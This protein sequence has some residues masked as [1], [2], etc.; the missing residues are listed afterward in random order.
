LPGI[1]APDKRI[2]NA[3]RFFR[4]DKDNNV[5]FIRIRYTMNDMTGIFK[6]C[7][8]V[9]LGVWILTMM[10]CSPKNYKTKSRSAGSGELQDK[11]A[12]A[13][14]FGELTRDDD[15]E[16]V[17]DV[18]NRFCQAYFGAKTDTLYYAYGNNVSIV[19]NSRWQYISERSAAIAW[20][21]NLPAKTYIEYGQDKKYGYQTA[22]QERYFF[23]HLHYLTKLQPGR[24]YYYR[25]VSLDETGRKTASEQRSFITPKLE[26]VIYLPGNQG[27]PPYVLD[28]ANTTYLVTEN[29]IADRSAFDIRAENITLDLGGNT[30][31][32]ASQLIHNLDYEDHANAGVGIRSINVRPLSGLKIY[33]GR[34]KQGD[35][36]NNLDYIAGDNMLDPDPEREK[37]LEKN[38]SR[39]FS[40]IEISNVGN[41][42]IAGV[43]VEYHL[44]QT[45]GMRFDKAF[46]SYDI[47]HNV[48]LD[49][50]VQMFNRHGDGGARSMGFRSLNSADSNLYQGDNAFK[51]SH[52]LVKRTRQNALNVAKQIYDNEIYVDSWSVN[53]FAIHPA[54]E[55]AEVHDNK[56][57]LTGYYGCG[58]LWSLKNMRV[59]RNFIHMEG[60]RTMIKK[61]LLGRRLIETWGEQ[62]VLAG[63]RVTNYGKGG[64]ERRDLL[65]EDNIIIGRSRGGGEMRGVEFFSDYSN[66][67]IVF[68]N[69]TVKIEAADTSGCKAACVDTQGAFNDRS[70]HLPV[71]YQNNNLISNIAIIRF[72]DEYGQG[73][74]HRFINCKLIRTGA[75]PDFHAFVFDGKNAVFNHALLDCEFGKGVSY[76]DVYWSNTESFSNYSVQWT[77]TL[78]T[79]PEARVTIRNRNGELFFS[80]NAGAKGLLDIPLVQSI[81]RPKEWTREGKNISVKPSTAFQEELFSPYTI[82]VETNGKSRVQTLEMN[83]KTTL[84]L[85]S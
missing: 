77:L 54:M 82:T 34:I 6:K 67:D 29:I 37:R 45:W 15:P 12:I 52:N 69:N 33:N 70:A 73:S 9:F 31:T 4:I 57:F 30:V 65:Y 40:N 19:E 35:A 47:H 41:V 58:I 36:K 44:P 56:I 25:I 48:Y 39:G 13:K 20:K 59:K 60:V 79:D 83:K 84:D 8:L 14:A 3:W 38:A 74:N 5:L 80:G 53:S 49:K 72:G 64:T 55:N 28:K 1:F 24:R 26:N 42:E 16:K 27:K 17:Y 50:G 62:D 46:G 32:H 21:T 66:H 81:I 63:M 18:F 43:S 78:K 10:S 68:K 23:I 22:P 76:N 71:Y 2:E 75:Y 61:P 85:R 51:I 7:I 11:A